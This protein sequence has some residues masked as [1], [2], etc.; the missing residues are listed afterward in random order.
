MFKQHHGANLPANA[1]AFFKGANEC[2]INQT[3][4]HYPIFQESSF[5]YLFGVFEM[6]CYGVIDFA[7]DKAIVFVPK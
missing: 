3:D 7:T 5:Y 2:Y 6:D 1:V 4:V